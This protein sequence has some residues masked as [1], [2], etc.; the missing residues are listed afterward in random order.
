MHE[1]GEAEQGVPMLSFDSPG[2]P[3]ENGRQRE[4]PGIDQ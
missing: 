2:I 4:I 1:I 3:I